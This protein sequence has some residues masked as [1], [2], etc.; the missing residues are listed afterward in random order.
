MRALR[1]GCSGWSYESWRGRLYP[2]H[3]SPSHW[4]EAY[5]ETFD[6]VEVNA[7]FYR[8]Q[9]RPA[10]EHWVEATPPA[11]SSRSRRAAT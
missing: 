11:S 10:V 3:L 2:E 9:R 8:L 4:L 5:A 6:T 7:T 1:V